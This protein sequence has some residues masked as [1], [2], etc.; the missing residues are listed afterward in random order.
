MLD[1]IML[2]L[3]VVCFVLAQAYAGLCNQLLAFAP[4]QNDKADSP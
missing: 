2:A 1:F 3:I 4:E